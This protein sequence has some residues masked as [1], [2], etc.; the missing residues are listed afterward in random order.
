LVD[1]S[2][3]LFC[4]QIIDFCSYIDCLLPSPSFSFNLF[5]LSSFYFQVRCYILLI[6]DLTSP[7]LPPPFSPPQSFFFTLGMNSRHIHAKQASTTWDMPHALSLLFQ[8]KYLMLY[9]FVCAQ[10]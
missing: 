2:E 9:I 6:G 5:F 1:I 3:L 4:F 10:L 8:Y 7:P